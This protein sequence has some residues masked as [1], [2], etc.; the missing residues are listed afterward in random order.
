MSFV[1]EL[2]VYCGPD[3]ELVREGQDAVNEAMIRHWCEAL[4]DRNPIYTDPKTP[5]ASSHRRP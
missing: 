1:E 3:W 5:G 2:R 4:E